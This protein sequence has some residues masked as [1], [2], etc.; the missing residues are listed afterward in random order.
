MFFVAPHDVAR[1]IAGRQANE[2]TIQ[3]VRHRLGLDQPVL[4]QYLRFLGRLGR[5]DLGESF[6]TSESVT[7]VIRR[8]F[9]ITASLALG[10]ATLW[11]FIGVSAGVM[12]ATRP[13]SWL[14]RAIN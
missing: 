3:L 12:S 5:G 11:L 1:L 2:Q 14:D 13:R 8:D 7:E 6:L 9:P 10:A 4:I